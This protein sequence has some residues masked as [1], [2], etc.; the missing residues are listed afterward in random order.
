MKGRGVKIDGD[1]SDGGRGREED[2]VASSFALPVVSL[3]TEAG[4]PCTA[5]RR[6]RTGV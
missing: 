6:R 3:S 2:Y 4:H 1:N 5:T